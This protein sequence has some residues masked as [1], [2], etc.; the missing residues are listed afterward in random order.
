MKKLLLPLLLVFVLF[1]GCAEVSESIEVEVLQ[2]SDV[3]AILTAVVESI[4]WEQLQ[5]Y[6]EKG[7]K[8]LV[9]K[10][11]SLKVL[12]DNEQMKALL[13]DKGLA[14]AGKL[15]EST[16]PEVQENARKIGEIIKILYPELT[17][18]VDTVL[19]K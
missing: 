3:E 16:E 7:A 4:D 5:T 19:Y 6:A 15:L 1:C 9:E 10:Y 2:I 13:K 11:P 12:A 14:L 18:D 8:A 17:E